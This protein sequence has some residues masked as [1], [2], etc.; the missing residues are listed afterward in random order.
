MSDKVRKEEEL[1]KEAKL[2]DEGTLTPAGWEDAPEAVPRSQESV[3]ISIQF[4]RQM[5]HILQE[6]ARREGIG[7]QVLLKRWLDD[8]I[9]LEQQRHHASPM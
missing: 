9:R 7:Y 3:A 5:V 1:A 6:F 4:P 8:R 2:W